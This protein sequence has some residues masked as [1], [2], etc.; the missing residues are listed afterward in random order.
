MERIAEPDA[1]QRDFG[2]RFPSLIL[3]SSSPNRKALLEKGGCSVTV[4][5]PDADERKEGA[6]PESIVASI[7]ERKIE[8][9]IS[10]E[11][12]S[13]LV[14]AIAADT[15]VH[16]D[17]EL[18]GKPENREHAREILTAL[19]GRKQEVITSAGVY[20]PG[21]G[22]LM[23]TDTAAVIFRPLSGGEI[24]EY[25]STGEWEGAAGGYR[26]QKTGYTLVERIEGDWTT[27][28]GLPLRKILEAAEQ[29]IHQIYR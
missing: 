13:P 19:S 7:A 3:A 17:G 28:V 27:V 26:L 18:L 5:V 14:P 6:A 29:R 15:L 16:I 23:V 24:E 11:R 2:K 25:L 10:S 22:K 20:L 8:A 1:L 21:E 4:F 12:F 9:Y